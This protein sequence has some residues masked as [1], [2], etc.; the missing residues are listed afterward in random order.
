MSTEVV[1]VKDPWKL[2]SGLDA[3]CLLL[4][5][6]N[7][8]FATV[9]NE[10][11]RKGFGFFFF[12]REKERLT[13]QSVVQKFISLAREPSSVVKIVGTDILCRLLS[14]TLKNNSIS[15]QKETIRNHSFELYFYPDDGR[16][17]VSVDQSPPNVATKKTIKVMVVDD[18]QTI[19]DLLTQ[20]IASDPDL[21]VVATISNPLEV[22]KN[23]DL[24]KPDVIT[25]DIHMPEMDG[26]TLLKKIIPKY[27]IPTVMITSI[28]MDEGPMVL[29]ALEAG[30]VDYI[31]KPSFKEL[32]AVSSV[33]V[34]KIK[35]AAHAKVN[36]KRSGVTKRS[37]LPT[38]KVDTSKLVA[39]GSSTGGTEALKEILINLPAEIPPIVIVQHI[40]AVFSLAF[41]NR[42]DSLCDFEVKEAEDGD[43]VTPNRVL[44]A[45]G[46]KQMRVVQR[47]GKLQVVVEDSPPVNRH[48]P[49]VDVL[50]H[51]VAEIAPEKTVGIILTGMGADGAKGLLALKKKGS[52]TIAQSEQSCV[53]FGMPR[54]AIKLGAADHIEDLENIATK[55]LEMVRL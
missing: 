44:I 28:S 21:T 36:R 39:I 34:E 49:S 1:R 10:N 5:E 22:E 25:L 15:V 18:S 47:G 43:A 33:M 20:V 53:V 19:R 3:P 30:A 26:V 24:H 23:I 27:H 51:S 48:K 17:R 31:Q 2:Y 42:M 35:N 45:P 12:E 13:T 54:E 11:K 40:P 9:Y 41:A 16:I 50:F 55:L 46:G 37:N 52:R 4:K 7:A 32:A 6:K 8:C 29:S 14:E 38:H